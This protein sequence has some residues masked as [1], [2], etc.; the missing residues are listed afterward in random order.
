VESGIYSLPI[1]L[2]LE[3]ASFNWPFFRLAPNSLLNLL[4]ADKQLEPYL[5]VIDVPQVTKGYRLNV[6]MD[7]T[8]NDEAIGFLERS[9]QND[10]IITNEQS[11]LGYPFTK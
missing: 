9:K 11:S 1:P 10:H 2:H 5:K 7:G 6:L 4:P 8:H 3:G